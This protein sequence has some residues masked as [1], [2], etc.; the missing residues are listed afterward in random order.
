MVARTARVAMQIY[1][2]RSEGYGRCCIIHR[3]P[4]LLHCSVPCVRLATAWARTLRYREQYPFCTGF[5]AV[6]KLGLVQ[7]QTS[8]AYHTVH[9]IVYCTMKV[10]I[11]I[12]DVVWMKGR[13]QHLDKS[14]N[15]SS[16][17]LSISQ[18]VRGPVSCARFVIKFPSEWEICIWVLLEDEA[19]IAP[20]SVNYQLSRP[21][22]KQTARCLLT[23]PLL[24][25]TSN[26]L[27]STETQEPNINSLY[28]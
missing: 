2:S 8:I 14:E 4:L 16:T 25:G 10:S 13:K 18:Q 3:P 24:H 1:T 28:R 26:S 19:N 6:L 20:R 7:D 17:S 15:T 5:N 23:Q 21:F 9:S 12:V 22:W 27:L 11:I